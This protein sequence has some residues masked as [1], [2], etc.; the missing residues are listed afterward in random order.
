[1]IPVHRNGTFQLDRVAVT[2]S[3]F[4]GL[5]TARD[6]DCEFTGYLGGTR[7]P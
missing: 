4:R 5:L 1:M 7:K 3:G 2:E 6:Q